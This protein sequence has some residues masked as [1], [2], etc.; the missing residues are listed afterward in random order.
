MFSESQELEVFTSPWMEM[1]PFR[2]NILR[3]RYVWLGIAMNLARARLP[4]I[5]W[6]KV[7]N[8]ATSK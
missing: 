6:Y 7:S 4:R 8:G 2:A 1:A 5:T 3:M